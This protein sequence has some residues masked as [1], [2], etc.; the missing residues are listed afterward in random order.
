M[1][2]NLVLIIGCLI[3]V[4]SVFASDVDGE[5]FVGTW[6]FEI[7][8]TPNGDTKNV[9][10]IHL[11]DDKFSGVMK[12]VDGQDFEL[13]NFSVDGDEMTFF[14]TAQGHEVDV[15]IELQSNNEFEGYLKDM[16]EVV[17]SRAKE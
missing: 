9:L 1:K 10:I 16:F 12:G 11:K 4:A 2:K 17:G 8:D 14:F 7:F 6:D 3:S 13:Y 15:V 5:K